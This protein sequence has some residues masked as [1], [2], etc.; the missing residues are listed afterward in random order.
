[1]HKLP[2]WKI[3]RSVG[4]SVGRSVDDEVWDEVCKLDVIPDRL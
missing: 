4:R 1:M 2:K 3:R